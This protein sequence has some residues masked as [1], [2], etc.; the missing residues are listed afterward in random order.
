[1]GGTGHC[2]GQDLA[3]GDDGEGGRAPTHRHRACVRGLADGAGG[4][5]VGGAPVV[6]CSAT[7]A[8]PGTQ[9]SLHRRRSHAH[10]PPTTIMHLGRTP[11]RPPLRS[12]GGQH[13]GRAGPL[14]S[15]AWP[16]ARPT[17]ALATVSADTLSGLAAAHRSPT[18]NSTTCSSCAAATAAVVVMVCGRGGARFEV[19]GEGGR[20]AGWVGG[21]R[22]SRCRLRGFAMAGRGLRPPGRCVSW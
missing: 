2:P 3:G 17:C 4:R 5:E 11:P 18:T 12:K 1:M 15:P 13:A 14:C 10:T 19:Q 7:S 16:P 8:V 9:S 22:G 6:R 21:D 20:A